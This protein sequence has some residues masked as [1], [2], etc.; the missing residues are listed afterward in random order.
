MRHTWPT[1]RA[2]ATP[3]CRP[4]IGA[5]R[6]GD[7]SS[8]ENRNPSPGPAH[9]PNAQPVRAMPAFPRRLGPD[10]PVKRAA[11]NEANVRSSYCRAAVQCSRRR[12]PASVGPRPIVAARVDEPATTI[13][14]CL[15]T[16]ARSCAVRE[17]RCELRLRADDQLVALKTASRRLC[18]WRWPSAFAISFGE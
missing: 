8:F 5:V 7:E 13:A 18:T 11:P 9:R 6:P 12:D 14:R 3:S 1:P 16:R 17:E 15:P 2:I 4:S 10:D